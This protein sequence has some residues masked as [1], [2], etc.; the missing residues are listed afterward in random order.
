MR[1]WLFSLFFSFCSMTIGQ[2]AH[3]FIYSDTVKVD[4]R[5]GGKLDSIDLMF[6]FQSSTIPGGAGAGYSDNILKTNWLRTN[7]NGQRFFSYNAWSGYRY[8]G[9]PHV[10]FAYAFGAQGTQ[11]VMAQYEQGYRGNVMLNIDFLK[12]RSNGF[13]R[14][15]SFD[16]NE[17]Q[18]KLFRNGEVYSFDLKSSF[19]KSLVSHSGG[20]A[21]DSVADE[22]PL[23]FI[24]VNKQ[25]AEVNTQRSRIELINYFDFYKDTNKAFGVYTS[26]DLK[27]KNYKYLE[28]GNLA[29]LYPVINYDSSNTFDQHQWSQVGNGA[30]FFLKKGYQFLSCGADV[31]F[32]N[33][34]NLGFYA[35]TLEVDLVGKYYVNSEKIS[36]TEDMSWNVLGA[37]KEFYNDLHL[38][39]HLPRFDIFGQ[40]L[41]QHLLPEYYQ[42]FST[43][44][45]YFS[46]ENIEKQQLID[47]K[48]GSEY[49]FGAQCIQLEYECAG[50][51]NNYWF[52]DS[53]WRNDTLDNVVF[54]S[55]EFSADLKV[56]RWSFHPE[57]KLTLNEKN[58]GIIPVHQF[59]TRILVK[60]GLF[61][62]KKMIA[63]GGLDLCAY[64]SFSL[65]GMNA[66]NST[67]RLDG[68]GNFNNGWTNAHLFGGFQIEE[69]KFYVR[70]E[71]LGYFWNDPNLELMNRFPI[72]STS[73]RLG[74]TWDFFN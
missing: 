21:L 8:S 40:L 28:N 32:W 9:I 16:H 67:F 26:H 11:L 36:L 5:I 60:G 38:K 63:Y 43:G 72:P 39:Y 22:F 50:A 69:F 1:F 49:D 59:R 7:P 20:V 4:R 34:Q 27:I 51:N 52:V 44:N 42:R 25:V 2:L 66:I 29:S 15:S 48:V 46:A 71:N 30:G 24:P 70:I 10:G 68:P 55:I 74:L 14:N 41:Y 54:Q 12:N 57:Y 33:F 31:Q 19:E 45:N 47:L 56:R 58:L 64:S 61:K 23:I 13:L 3:P 17:L 35:D 53:I 18:L 65:I 73:F 6:K 37:Q 62:A